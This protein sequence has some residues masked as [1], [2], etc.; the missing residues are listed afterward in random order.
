ML[1][2]ERHLKYD[3]CVEA[4]MFVP[5][6]RLYQFAFRIVSPLL[7]WRSPQL[8]TGAGS[9][10]RIPKLVQELHVSSILV[11][12]DKGI[13]KAGII[14]PLLEALSAGGIRTWV[15]DQ[16]VQ[17]PT[18]QNIEDALAIYKA[19]GCTAILAVGGGS[20][21]DCAKIVGARVAR[22]HKQVSSM[23]GLFKVLRRLPPIIA[24]PTTAGTGSETTLAAV[25]TDPSRHQKYP[26]NDFCL[27]PHSAVLD[28]SL[29]IGLPPAITATTGMDALTHAVEAFI[30][31]SNTRSTQ[32]DAIEASRLILSNLE[33]VY[34][35][36]D[37][38][39]GRNAMLTASFLAGK[40]FTRAY[41]GN[42]HAMAHAIGGLY[43]VPHGLANAIILPH[44]L[45][46]YGKKAHKRLAALARASGA[47]S[48]QHSDE[49]TA[50]AFIQRIQAMNKAIGIPDHID[51]IQEADIPYLTQHALKEANPLYPVPVVLS[52]RDMESLFRI[53]GGCDKKKAA[54]S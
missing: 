49:E 39:D 16:V 46:Y 8:I 32:A 44:V 42:V 51:A 43:G 37:S 13:V 40:A 3:C 9:A 11:V 47:C 1:A 25:I 27:I 24:V 7:P 36:P 29:C 34:H 18:I 30:G 54:R 2:K 23:K 52:R 33:Q 21:L 10:G 48:T 28:P 35:H 41:V 12:T 19:K 20:A 38:I 5:Y 17:N 45:R 4:A 26:I 14:G 15:Y 53:A 22:P 6:A 50:D 31:Q